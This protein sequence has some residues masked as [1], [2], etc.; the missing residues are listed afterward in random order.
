MGWIKVSKPERLVQSRL[1]KAGGP[2]VNDRSQ[3]TMK[4][5]NQRAR[6]VNLGISR[7]VG[8]AIRESGPSLFKGPEM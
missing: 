4:L 3:N 2:E 5:K 1:S 8:D 7:W 6:A